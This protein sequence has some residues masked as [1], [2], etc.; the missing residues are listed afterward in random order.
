MSSMHIQQ[1]GMIGI[2]HV[3]DLI[4]F[5]YKISI[6]WCFEDMAVQEKIKGKT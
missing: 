3:H 5:C 6:N 1:K 2:C 4:I